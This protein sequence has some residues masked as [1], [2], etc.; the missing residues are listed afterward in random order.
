MPGLSTANQFISRDE[1]IHAEFAI[2]LYKMLDN[3]LS[4]RMVHALFKDA[5]DIEREFITESLPVSLIGMN[6][7]L[8]SQYIE[9]VA[10]RWLVLLGYNKLYNSSNP[11]GFM[12][13]ISVN[14]KVNFFENV[15]SNYI[16]SNVGQSE[17]DRQITFDSD[18]F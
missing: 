5:V 3:K 18:D 6:N 13:L 15:N 7:H 12:E 16:K 10:D 14:E 1:N 2:E 8:M 17:E 9:Y 4:E 11:F